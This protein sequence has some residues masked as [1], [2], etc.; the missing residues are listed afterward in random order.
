MKKLI[1]LSCLIGVTL[2][3]SAQEHNSASIKNP[4]SEGFY[5][6]LS[7]HSEYPT[8]WYFEANKTTE[9][10]HFTTALSQELWKSIKTLACPAVLSTIK[11]VHTEALLACARPHRDPQKAL[12]DAH[13][14]VQKVCNNLEH[15]S[16]DTYL[17]ALASLTQELSEQLSKPED[18]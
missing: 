1:I 12:E 5:T 13:T 4:C 15:N 2:L 7:S 9:E 17:A 14:Q 11:D 6:V 3:Q 16:K 8:T 18:A 10:N